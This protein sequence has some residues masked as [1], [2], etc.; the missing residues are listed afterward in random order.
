MESMTGFGKG[1][2]QSENFSI[3]VYAKSLNHRF[4]EVL[5]KLPKRYSLLE[6]RIRKLIASQL[7]RGK[8]EITVKLAGILPFSK[9]IY[10][11][12]ELAKNLKKVL[13]ILQEKLELEG[14]LT[15][16]DFLYFKEFLAFEEKEEEI[17]ILWE[18]LSPALRS[19]LEEL[20]K[21]RE[22][23]GEF[24]EKV[25]KKLL[26]ELRDT[27]SEIEKLK[28][29]AVKEAQENVKKRILKLLHELEIKTLDESRFYQELVYFL[30]KFDFTE[31]LERLKIHLV[32]FEMAMKEKRCGKK[33]D[34]LCQEMF[35]EINTLSNKA[36]S[37]EI[38]LLAVKVK[39]LIEKIREQVQNVV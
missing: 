18:E 2:F 24:L 16:S 21:S 23:E 34:F 28:E 9:D 11:D 6:E 8:I 29:R 3:T 32:H 17:E 20:K 27:L 4:L 36:H 14:K 22:R 5:L 10:L 19:A 26:L 30:D 38:S 13:E 15:L 33:L 12:L 35:R 31:E 37:S 1:V 7:E 25:L 39:D